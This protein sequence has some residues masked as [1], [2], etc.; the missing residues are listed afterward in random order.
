MGWSSFGPSLQFAKKILQSVLGSWI[1]TLSFD[2]LD[3]RFGMI[4]HVQENLT[5]SEEIG[6]DVTG[7]RAFV[8]EIIALGNKWP[9]IKSFS[10]FDFF[11]EM[12]LKPSTKA[13]S[14]MDE[15]TKKQF[16]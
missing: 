16:V 8:D 9:E 4:K 10:N 13:K 7:A 6:L 2:H 12:F 5:E 14:A 11:R 15:Q 3:A 1:A